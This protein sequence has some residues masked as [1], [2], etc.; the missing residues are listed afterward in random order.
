MTNTNFPLYSLVKTSNSV[1][2]KWRNC[3]GIVVKNLTYGMAGTHYEVIIQGY[4]LVFRND[5]ITL[6]D[7]SNCERLSNCDIPTL[8]NDIEKNN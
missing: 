3:C 7:C 4:P 8:Q 5:E 1:S 2:L 6:C